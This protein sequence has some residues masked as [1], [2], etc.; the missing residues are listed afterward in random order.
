MGKVSPGM[1][2]AFLWSEIKVFP[3]NRMLMNIEL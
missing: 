2:S 1:L 3:R